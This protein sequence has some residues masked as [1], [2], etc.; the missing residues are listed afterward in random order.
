MKSIPDGSSMS[1]AEQ[2]AR[3]Y[4]SKYAVDL[5]QY[6]FS[7]DCMDDG[8]SN[9]SGYD[10]VS[11]VHKVNKVFIRVQILSYQSGKKVPLEV[12]EVTFS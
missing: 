4:L 1:P 8:Q 12:Y 9:G 2:L 11:F 3:D 7:H 10:F 6:E 5:T